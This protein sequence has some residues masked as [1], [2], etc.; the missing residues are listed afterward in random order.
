MDYSLPGSSVHG[1]S[2]Q[3]YWSG[4]PF[5]SPGDLPDPG[6]KPRSSALAGRF[7]TTEPPGKP[8]S[9]NWLS[10]NKLGKTS[11]FPPD[12]WKVLSLCRLAVLY[13]TKFCSCELPAANPLNGT[14]RATHPS[15]LTVFAL[16]NIHFS[17]NLCFIPHCI[18]FLF[19]KFWYTPIR[20]IAIKLYFPEVLCTEM[21]GEKKNLTNLA[22]SSNRSKQFSWKRVM[23]FERE[24]L[25][26]VS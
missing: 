5:P 4:L 17:V 19:K 23:N 1:F 6:I 10:G 25:V 3:E 2:R 8:H 13:F 14:V 20:L 21:S 24:Q 12:T 16:Y 18:L 15:K 26:S 22:R 11:H 9:I 7:F